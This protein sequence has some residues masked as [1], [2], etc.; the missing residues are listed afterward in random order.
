MMNSHR[1]NFY[2]SGKITSLKINN[3]NRERERERNGD[4]IYRDWMLVCNVEKLDF[5]IVNVD[6][7]LY[8]HRTIEVDVFIDFLLK[9][10]KKKV[11]VLNVFGRR[12][13]DWCK[14]EWHKANASKILKRF[15]EE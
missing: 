15:I 6:I 4:D 14:N 7:S 5:S 12:W 1:K 10:N 8:E 11:R 13:N 3:R 2:S 9:K